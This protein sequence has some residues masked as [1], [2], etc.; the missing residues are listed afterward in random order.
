[1]SFKL[2]QGRGDSKKQTK[3]APNRED[4]KKQRFKGVLA[5]YSNGGIR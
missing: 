5:V 4:V 1:M 2:W 3:T